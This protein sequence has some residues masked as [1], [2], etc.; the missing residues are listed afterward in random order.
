MQDRDGVIELD[1]PVTGN[2]DDPN[3]RVGRVVWKQIVGIVTK[4]A[5]APFTLL[6]KLFGGGGSQKLDVVDFE[7]GS[8][9]LTPKTEKTLQALA[10]AVYSRPALRLDVEGSADEKADGRALRVA[11]LHRRG[12]EAKWKAS[13]NHSGASSPDKVELLEDEYAKFIESAYRDLPRGVGGAGG[14]GGQ[15]PT[16]TEME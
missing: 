7:P 16:M 11:E 5:T 15:K 10:N 6:A 12:Q 14:S 13:K 2:L 1:V 3:F 8:S 9:A 4:V